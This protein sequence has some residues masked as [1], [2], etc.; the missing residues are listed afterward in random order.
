MHRLGC[1]PEMPTFRQM[2]KNLE[3]AQIYDRVSWRLH[4]CKGKYKGKKDVL[5]YLVIMLL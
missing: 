2:Q 1:A 4:V 3:I 5:E